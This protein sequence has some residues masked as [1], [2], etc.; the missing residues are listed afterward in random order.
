MVGAAGP[1]QGKR[2]PLEI[3][4]ITALSVGAAMVLLPAIGLK[5]LVGKLPAVRN[6]AGGA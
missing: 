3:A 4:A 6:A 2:E 1:D 5:A